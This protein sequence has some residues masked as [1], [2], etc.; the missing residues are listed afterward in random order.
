MSDIFHTLVEYA[1]TIRNSVTGPLPSYSCLSMHCFPPDVL[2]S[3]QLLRLHCH[4]RMSPS[5]ISPICNVKQEFL[6]MQRT[7]KH[8]DSVT[9]NFDAC[10][11]TLSVYPHRASLENMPGHGGNRTYDHWN[12]N[13]E[14]NL[15]RFCLRNW[16]NEVN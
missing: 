1:S 4:D 2:R 3:G 13:T 15:N 11:V 16:S 7:Q 6:E 12:T 8:S 9:L 5:V 14:K 10:D